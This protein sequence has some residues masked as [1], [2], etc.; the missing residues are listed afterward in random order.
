[1]FGL[2]HSITFRRSGG[3][4]CV[5]FPPAGMVCQPSAR[6]RWLRRFGVAS[7]AGVLACLLVLS[8]PDARA[9]N[10]AVDLAGRVVMGAH[11]LDKYQQYKPTPTAPPVDIHA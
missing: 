7:T 2:A 8:T 10:V 11:V 5:T 9:D 1:M 6:N 3:E 4:G